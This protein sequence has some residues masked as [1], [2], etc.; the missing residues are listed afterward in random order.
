VRLKE[1]LERGGNWSEEKYYRMDHD[2]CVA[3]IHAIEHESEGE[4][5]RDSTDQQAVVQ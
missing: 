2:F 1:Y 3:M 4:R 5:W